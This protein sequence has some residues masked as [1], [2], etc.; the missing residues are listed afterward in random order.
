MFDGLA[1]TLDQ[2]TELDQVG[3]TVANAAGYEAGS[4]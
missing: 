3:F 1:T 2:L 4:W